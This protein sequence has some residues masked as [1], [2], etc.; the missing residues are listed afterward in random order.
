MY[1]QLSLKLTLI[2]A[3]KWSLFILNRLLLDR[4]GGLEVAR[5]DARNAYAVLV[6]Q[7]VEYVLFDSPQ[8]DADRIAL[9]TLVQQLSVKKD[10]PEWVQD[11]A[12]FLMPARTSTPRVFD[13]LTE[14]SIEDLPSPRFE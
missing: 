11:I 7:A 1:H 5:R 3:E 12:E 8:R 2:D 14:H 6:K 9:R 4:S 13:A 10:A